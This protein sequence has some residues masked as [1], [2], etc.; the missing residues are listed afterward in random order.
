MGFA[1]SPRIKPRAELCRRS[2][3]PR[4]CSLRSL[5]AVATSVAWGCCGGSCHSRMAQTSAQSMLWRCF[6][7]TGRAEAES[8]SAGWAGFELIDHGD[9]LH[10][11]GDTRDAPSHSAAQPVDIYALKFRKPADPRKAPARCEASR[12]LGCGRLSI[13]RA[14]IFRFRY[15]CEMAAEGQTV[16]C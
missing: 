4:R 8:L 1:V 12:H 7:F 3:K 10:V 9:F 13:L 5:Y 6:G 16:R 15:R 14:G 11:P 2:P